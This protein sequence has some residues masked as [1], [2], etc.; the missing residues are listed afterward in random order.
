MLEMV[1]TVGL[2]K[3]HGVKIGEKMVLGNYF[4]NFR[5]ILTNQEEL[6]LERFTLAVALNSEQ[7]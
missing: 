1:R 6:G 3:I 5:C 2:L 4:Y 7:I